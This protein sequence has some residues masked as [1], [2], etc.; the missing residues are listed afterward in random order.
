MVRF[1]VG[2]DLSDSDKKI[3]EETDI[4]LDKLVEK[5]GKDAS[6]LVN[7]IAVKA[8]QELLEQKS[9]DAYKAED[10]LLR[11]GVITWSDLIKVRKDVVKGMLK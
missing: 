3:S 1:D 9:A 7:E 6:E 8:M 4:L 2:S 10:L 5:T 11:E